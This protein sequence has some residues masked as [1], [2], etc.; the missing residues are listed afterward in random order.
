MKILI[1]NDDGIA[2]E[3][4]RAL[5]DW[6]KNIGD[7]SVFAP[8]VEQSGKSA[9]LELQKAFHVEKVD[10]PGAVEAYA[11]DSTPVDCVRF[12][13]LCMGRKFD[14]VLSG[15]NKGQNLGHDIN[16]SGTCG[17][18]F[19]AAMQGM[20]GVALSAGAKALPNAI[21]CFDRV[22]KYFVDNNLLSLCDIYNVNFPNGEAGDIAIT[23]QG[24]I[25]FSD[26]YKDVG[27]NMYFPH[28]YTCFEL[29]GNKEI[30]IDAINMG[31]I[32]VSPLAYERTNYKAFELLK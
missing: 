9:S 16:Y 5:V 21:A 26:E 18:V 31:Y 14:L 30:D 28:S 17:A 19:E 10:Y 6:A 24:G 27:D 29:S 7:V 8:K 15:V 32:S 22:Y 23:R 4:L 11:V 2:S 20:K 1:T 25:R 13:V 3:G 12:A